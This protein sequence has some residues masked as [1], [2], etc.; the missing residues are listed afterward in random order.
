MKKDRS[1]V[2]VL[3]LVLLFAIIF[4]PANSAYA[5][6]QLYELSELNLTVDIPNDMTVFTRDISEDDPRLADFG[7]SASVMKETF[8]QNNIYLDAVSKD[9]EKELMIL[10]NSNEDS[11]KM[12]NLSES[13]DSELDKSIPDFV[14][15]VEKTSG[16]TINNTTIYNNGS[17]KFY[18]MNYNLNSNGY[19]TYARNYVTIYNGQMI[20]VFLYSY[21][22]DISD[23]DASMLKSIVDSITFTKTLDNPNTT[24]SINY[25]KLGEAF[26]ILLTISV[27]SLIVF[28][29]RK[30][31]KKM[32]KASVDAEANE[33]TNNQ[34]NSVDLAPFCYGANSTDQTDNNS[35][36]GTVFC[37]KCGEKIPVDSEFCTK[38]GSSVIRL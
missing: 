8:T 10:M 3:T 18:V 22:S 14:K 23:T 27:I 26:M 31:R 9:A 36:Q 33:E 38:C 11:I 28:K 32:S 7:L 4:F 20:S 29:E 13:S 19:I 12:F 1:F 30:Y 37:R 34:I 5:A 35:L 21:A 15:G 17:Y 2:N 24:S 16:Y 6:P 25:E